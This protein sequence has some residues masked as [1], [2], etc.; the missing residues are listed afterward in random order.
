M[1]DSS[2]TLELASSEETQAPE[3]KKPAEV[4]AAAE[5]KEAAEAE[6]AKKKKKK[7]K[8]KRAKRGAETFYRVAYRTH[9]DLS[10]IADN[11]ANMMISINGL[12]MS[13][14]LAA[15]AANIAP[16]PWMFIPLGLLL[17]TS[18]GSIIFA[19]LCAVP[20]V[21]KHKV[22]LDDVRAGKKSIFFFGNFIRMPQ[23]DYVI[24]MQELTQD[25]V[26]LRENMSRDLY[27]LG[28][29]LDQKFRYLRTSYAVFLT[30]LTITLVTFLTLFFVVGGV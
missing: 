27:M 5:A 13:V 23:E 10:S 15:V 12:I 4:K 28:I 30:G 8:K 11:K 2:A 17:L 22:S 24:G 1:S 29:V 20:R 19:I 18:F 3:A 14:M 21:N 16:E 26:R 9:I 7:R 25:R 6:Q